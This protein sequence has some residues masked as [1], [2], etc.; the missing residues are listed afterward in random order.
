MPNLCRS[1]TAR[2]RSLGSRT[3]PPDAHSKASL[4]TLAVAERKGKSHRTWPNL[5]ILAGRGTAARGDRPRGRGRE[6]ASP[7]L[8][9]FEPVPERLVGRV[10]VPPGRGLRRLGRAA[11]LP[12]APAA[13]GLVGPAWVLGSLLALDGWLALRPDLDLPDAARSWGLLAVA[14]ANELASHTPNPEAHRLRSLVLPGAYLVATSTDF[15]GPGWVVP[16]VIVTVTVGGPMAA[17]LDRRGARLGLG[18]LLLAHHGRRRLRHR[19]DTELIR[20]LVGV[21]LPLVLCAWPYAVAP[22][23]RGGRR[24][25]SA[26][27]VGRRR[28]RATGGPARSSV[29]AAALGLF[30]VEPLGRA[31]LRRRGCRGRGDVDPRVRARRSSAVHLLL[32]CLRHARRGLPGRR[33]ARVRCCGSPGSSPASSLGGLLGLPEAASRPGPAARLRAARVVEAIRRAPPGPAP[34]TEPTIASRS[35]RASASR[36]PARAAIDR[37]ARPRRRA[38]VAER[39]RRSAP[40]S[41]ASPSAASTTWSTDADERGRARPPAPRSTSWS[42]TWLR[43][44]WNSGRRARSRR[45]IAI[46]VSATRQ[47]DDSGTAIQTDQ[48]VVAVLGQRGQRARARCPIRYAPPSPRYIRAGG[49]LNT[50]KRRARRRA[51]APIGVGV[52]AEDRERRRALTTHDAGGEAVLAVEQVHRV[53]QAR[54]RAR[55]VA[56]CD[57]RRS[58]DDEPRRRRRSRSRRRAGPGAGAAAASSATPSASARPYGTSS[59]SRLAPRSGRRAGR[60]TP[61]RHRG[62]GPATRWVLSGPGRSTMPSADRDRAGAMRRA[63]RASTTSATTS[64]TPAPRTTRPACTSMPRRDANPHRSYSRSAAAL[65]DPVDDLHRV[66]A[67]RGELVGRGVD[68]RAARCPRPP[69]RPSTATARISAAGQVVAVGGR[70]AERLEHAAPRPDEL[71][72]GAH[73][74]RRAP[75][76]SDERAVERADVCRRRRRSRRR[77]RSA[78]VGRD[79][80]ERAVGRRARSAGTAGRGTPGPRLG[81]EALGD[82][83]GVQ[84][85]RAAAAS[86]STGERGRVTQSTAGRRPR[87]RS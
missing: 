60:G 35:G 52:A 78:V 40:G 36:N 64:S 27:D 15:A 37:H 84:L 51:R 32:V 4:W 69:R 61:R 57:E 75:S 30:L 63:R 58:R 77:G 50:R 3:G 20:P 21:A 47:P 5:G 23:G 24:G 41:A 34:G 83:V 13:G 1:A 82:P 74:R 66:D 31:L 7:T 11:L 22:L 56:T 9:E 53:E 39:D 71:R 42:Y 16:L 12:D 76:R 14:A 28:S 18:P 45:T 54:R 26:P 49:A 68:Q 79:A 62:T 46:A 38:V 2:V 72:R 19:P 48:S 80:R 86:A 25:G 17:D 43:S 73:A 70:V 8:F 55:A 29:A 87:S 81:E 65:S 6:P 59:A 33:R 44:P 85:R 67:A 10:G